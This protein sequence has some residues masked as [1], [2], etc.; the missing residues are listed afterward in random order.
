MAEGFIFYASFYEAIC[1]LDESTQAKCYDAIMRYGLYGEEPTA[2]GIVSA[3]YKLV[4]PQIDANNKR[5]EAGRKGGKAP[6]KQTE[7]NGSKDEANASKSKQTQ[8]KEKEKVKV[9]DKVK[10]KDKDKRETPAAVIAQLPEE[11]QEC[12]QEFVKMRDRIKAPVTA[13][14]LRKLISKA[15]KL[16]DGRTEIIRDIFDQST[17]NA[18]KGV[19]EVKQQRG[20]SAETFADLLREEIKHEQDGSIESTEPTGGVL[21]TG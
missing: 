3:V 11:L 7:A 18:W 6:A 19:F 1:E 17:A 4:K 13:Y 8:A 2:G 10:E 9:K 15:H 5:R 20:A 14:G 12:V 21:W 16:A